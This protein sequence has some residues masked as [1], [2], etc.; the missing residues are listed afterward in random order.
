MSLIQGVDGL[1]GS[2][3][4]FLIVTLVLIQ[5]LMLSEVITNLAF[6]LVSFYS[7]SLKVPDH[8]SSHP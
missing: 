2:F 4:A 3:K 8:Y 5:L 6:D 7:S 1:L